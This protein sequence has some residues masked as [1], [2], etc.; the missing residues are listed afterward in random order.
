LNYLLQNLKKMI[1][2]ES[3]DMKRREEELSEIEQL[4]ERTA[5]AEKEK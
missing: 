2:W 5:E 1:K 4:N 3:S